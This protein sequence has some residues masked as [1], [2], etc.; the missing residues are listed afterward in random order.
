MIKDVPKEKKNK[1]FRMKS[2]P[3]MK[4]EKGTSKIMNT[5]CK[6]FPFFFQIGERYER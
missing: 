1:L 5:G 3:K 2:E 6:I 4:I